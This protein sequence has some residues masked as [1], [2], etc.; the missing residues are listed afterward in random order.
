M[1]NYKE[2]EK[3]VYDWLKSK[4]EGDK[5]F[6]FSLRMK[7]SKNNE[8]DY[9]IGTENSKYFGTTF[10]TLPVNYPGS[11]SDCINLIFGYRDDDYFYHFE[12]G[13]TQSPI[14]LQNESALSLIK[15]IKQIETTGIEFTRESDEGSK[16]YNFK[17]EQRQSN[18]VNLDDMFEDIEEDME[19]I[20]PIVESAIELEKINNPEFIANRIT[21]EEFS[22]MEEKMERRFK[23]YAHLAECNYWIFQGNPKVYNIVNALKGGHLKSWKVA[24]HKNKI[25]KGDKVSIWQVGQ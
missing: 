19:I 9:F 4:N 15:Y 24:A 12:F 18:Y 5:N 23:K 13:Q 25:T 2:Y 7:G 22:T 11:S 3:V 1:I 17:V 21:P 6:T 14:G 10:W 8:L 20:I 16:M